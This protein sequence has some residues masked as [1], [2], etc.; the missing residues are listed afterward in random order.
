M[1]EKLVARDSMINRL[2]I[3]LYYNFKKR[4][5]YSKH[6]ILKKREALEN[7]L[8]PYRVEENLELLKKAGFLKTDVFF[9]WYNFAGFIAIKK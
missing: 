9:K 5:G 7:I 8:V 4:Q 1:V 2:Y 3:D 6:E